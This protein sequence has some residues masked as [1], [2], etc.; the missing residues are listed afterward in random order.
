MWIPTVPDAILVVTS[1]E[2]QGTVSLAQNYYS[3]NTEISLRTVNKCGL[4]VK[5][6]YFVDE[7]G[8]SFIELV[9]RPHC[10]V[11]ITPS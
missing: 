10:N 5:F 1:L 2:V 3:Q 7:C 8:I 6:I 9:W 4:G 11:V